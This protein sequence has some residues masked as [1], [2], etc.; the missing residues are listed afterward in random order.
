[1]HQ[2]RN[3]KGNGSER[4]LDS[5]KQHSKQVLAKLGSMGLVL[6]GKLALEGKA[7][8]K[9]LGMVLVDKVLGMVRCFG[10]IRM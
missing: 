7:A 9:V 8:D 2:Q 4:V 5:Y 6:V 3:P 1:L 10:Q